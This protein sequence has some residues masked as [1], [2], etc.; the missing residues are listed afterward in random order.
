L[1][2]E[3]LARLD[4][5]AAVVGGGAPDVPQPTLAA[6]PAQTNG[7]AVEKPPAAAVDSAPNLVPSAQTAET[8]QT[9][10]TATGRCVVC[11]E[12]P[13]R[14]IPRDCPRRR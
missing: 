1:P 12:D 4:R 3:F 13:Y 7:G 5:A 11:D 6:A 2:T 8:A 10:V 9:P 14:C